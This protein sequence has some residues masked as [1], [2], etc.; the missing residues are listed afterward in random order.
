MEKAREIIRHKLLEAG[1]CAVGFAE[2]GDVAESDWNQFRQWLTRGDNA[3]MD[4]MHNYPELRRN[5]EG[6]LENAKSL[7]SLAFPY[8]PQAGRELKGISDYALYPDYHKELRKILKPVIKDFEKEI[9]NS[10]FRICIDSA[11]VMERYWAQKAGIGFK[12]DNGALIVPGLGSMVFLV[13]IITNLQL[14]PDSPNEEDCGHCG[15]CMRAC[16]GKAIRGDGTID[17]RRCISYLTIEHN[18]DWNTPESQTVMNTT[19]GK[20]TLFGCDI[21]LK[22]CPHNRESSPEIIPALTRMNEIDNVSAEEILRIEDDA[23]LKRRFPDSPISRA[24]IIGLQR[25]AKNILT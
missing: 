7:V 14:P 16:P 15:A 8:K 20:T 11:P 1:A 5:P 3:G 22:V 25:N 23:E 2:A 21:C 9:R 12:G 18:G 17:C 10:H 4:Y 24:G 6:L 13:E 19:V